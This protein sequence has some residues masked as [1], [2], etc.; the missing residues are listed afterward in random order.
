M[1][2][3]LA[4]TAHQVMDAWAAKILSK[5]ALPDNVVGKNS[6][7]TQFIFEA[8]DDIPLFAVV[9][10]DT[11]VRLASNDEYDQVLGE[12][13]GGRF[14]ITELD[15]VAAVETVIHEASGIPLPVKRLSPESTPG[16]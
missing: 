6:S 7:G 15:P 12:I 11:K 1:P 2:I 16:L 9:M 13:A 10:E 14:Q 5:Q 4:N 8:W 3:L